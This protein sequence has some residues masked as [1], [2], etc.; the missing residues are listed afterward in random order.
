MA[1]ES[2]F[3]RPKT[4]E[5]AEGLIF[6]IKLFVTSL[7]NVLFIGFGNKT[8]CRIQKRVDQSRTT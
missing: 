1:D 4:H 6:P 7:S 8:K 5:G 2:W 3:V